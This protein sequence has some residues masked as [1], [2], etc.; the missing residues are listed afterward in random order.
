M[1]RPAPDSAT[2]LD[3]G[4]VY[5]E[6]SSATRLLTLDEPL[7]PDA[8]LFLGSA[9]ARIEKEGGMPRLLFVTAEGPTREA[10]LVALGLAR[11]AAARGT[12]VLLADLSVDSPV[13]AKPFPYQPEEGF[14][15]MVLWGSSYPAVLRKSRNER[16]GIVCV[17]SPPPD[18]DALFEESACDAVLGTFRGENEL[19]VA[20]GRLRSSTGGASPLLRKA[21]RT[22]IVRGAGMPVPDLDGVVPADRLILVTLGEELAVAGPAPSRPRE[23]AA[24]PESAPARPREKKRLPV[25]R[26]VLAFAG[27]CILVGLVLSSFYTRYREDAA[28]GRMEIARG[29]PPAPR[30]AGRPETTRPEAPTTALPGVF[31]GSPDA[32]FPLGGG[33]DV[34]ASRT[35]PPAP[36]A[37]EG[38]GAADE[39]PPPSD[40]TGPA[41]G[42][43][44]VAAE[45]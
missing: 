40:A 43:R 37:G 8:D 21:D 15:D 35:E 16:I 38:A 11:V 45:E 28:K 7:P 6:A 13:L 41:S 14:V 9:L 32:G 22:L 33:E 24:R 31:P 1:T 39:V 25:V 44:E 26:V 12:R 2:L 27:L 5:L 34:A 3:L 23:A 36:V 19:V 17:G 30:P 18:P 29:A 20:I 42:M 4:V 10:G